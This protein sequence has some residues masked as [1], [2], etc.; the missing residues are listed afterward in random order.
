MSRRLIVLAVL[1]VAGSARADDAIGDATGD[2]G[3]APDPSASTAT[4]TATDVADDMGDQGVGATLGLA[5][6]GRVTA[7]GLRVAG[8]YLYQLSDQDWFDGIAAFTFGSGAGGC[9]RDRMDQV[10]CDHGLAEGTSLEIAGGVRRM[11]AA[12]GAFRPFARVALG[13]AYTRF[14]ND[15][16]SGVSIPLHAAGGLRARVANGV[17]VVGMAELAIGV[18]SFGRGL[19]AEPLVGFAVTAGAEFRLR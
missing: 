6:G 14:S 16:V 15:D 5:L 18:G 9:F 10:Q 12:Q 4:T 17:A 11:F 3:V 8:D 2:L 13:L 19:G 1:G 7:G